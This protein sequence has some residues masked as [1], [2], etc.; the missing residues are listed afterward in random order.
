MSHGRRGRRNRSRNRARR[1]RCRECGE[2][3]KCLEKLTPDGKKQRRACPNGH[4]FVEDRT[5]PSPY[6]PRFSCRRCDKPVHVKGGYCDA[7]YQEIGG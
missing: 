2:L 4:E 6:A 5:E 3:T 1:V 7:C